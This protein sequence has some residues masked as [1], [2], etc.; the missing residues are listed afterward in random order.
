MS[1][2]VTGWQ[3][4]SILLFFP[5]Y[6][7]LGVLSTWYGTKQGYRVIVALLL[8]WFITPVGALLIFRFVPKG[9]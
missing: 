6:L 9:K 7:G 2:G 8:S 5:V 4:I 1:N 3:V